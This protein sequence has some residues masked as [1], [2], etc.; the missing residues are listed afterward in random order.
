MVI[1]G[2]RRGCCGSDG[3]FE[4]EKIKKKNGDNLLMLKFRMIKKVF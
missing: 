4:G 3:C 1:V 2:V